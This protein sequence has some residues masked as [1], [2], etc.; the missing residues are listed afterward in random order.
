MLFVVMVDVDVDVS[1]FVVV[2]GPRCYSVLVS[3]FEANLLGPV[4]CANAQLT[5][6]DPADRTMRVQYSV[7]FR[8]E[9]AVRRT[10]GGDS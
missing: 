7:R 9:T 8:G 2:V 6:V 5:H 1:F 4:P 3:F 10:H